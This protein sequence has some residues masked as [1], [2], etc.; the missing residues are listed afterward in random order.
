[1]KKSKPLHLF[2]SH[3]TEHKQSAETLAQELKRY[4]IK[5][6]VAHKDIEPTAEWQKEINDF[7]CESDCMLAMLHS[8][9]STSTWCNQEVGFCVGRNIPIISL[10]FEEEPQG[11]IGKCQAYIPQHH[12]DI[13]LDAPEIVNIIHKKAKTKDSIRSWLINSFYSSSS[14][15]STE[16]LC[17]AIESL[18]L[19]SQEIEEIKTAFLQNPEVSGMH[20]RMRHILGDNWVDTYWKQLSK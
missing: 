7:L 3:I 8:G 16:I 12:M 15:N 20:K 1:M 6:F 9:Y 10:K 17:K 13:K 19:T 5:P 2:I 18:T 14:Y 11:F 4:N